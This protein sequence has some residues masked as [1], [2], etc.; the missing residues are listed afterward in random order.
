MQVAFY[1]FMSQN[2]KIST[3]TTNK[4][5][6]YDRI[7]TNIGNGYDVTTGYFVVPEG[8]VYAFHVTTVARDK[9]HCSVELVKNEIVKDI[10]W[11]DAMDHNDRA[12]SSI[13]TVLQVN[14]GDVI[15]VRVGSAY[16][17]NLLE[18]NQYAR[19]SFSGFKIV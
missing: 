1:A 3:L 4:T 15:R 12:S 18:S 6:L 7:E 14:E 10:G 9:S 19:L 11:A 8:G 5:L 17:G 2:I 16:A 13:F